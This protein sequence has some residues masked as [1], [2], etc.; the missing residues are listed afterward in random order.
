MASH[1]YWWGWVFLIN[2]PVAVIGLIA[3]ATLIPES[4]LVRRP[5]V[6]LLG[7]L[8]SAAGLVALMVRVD[9]SGSARLEQRVGACLHRDGSRGPGRFLR[10]RAALTARAR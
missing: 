6:D 9:R 2:V 7:V 8:T 1:H 5:R 10:P 4:R 3:G